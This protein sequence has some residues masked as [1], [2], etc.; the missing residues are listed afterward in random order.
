M[1]KVDEKLIEN[2]ALINRLLEQIY[3]RKCIIF[4]RLPHSSKGPNCEGVK[5]KI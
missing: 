3:L 1:K 2:M 4:Y 5:S